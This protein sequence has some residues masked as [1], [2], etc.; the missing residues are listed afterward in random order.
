MTKDNSSDVARIAH[1]PVLLIAGPGTGKTHQLAKRIR[2][3]V[4]KNVDPMTIS[5]IT[6]TGC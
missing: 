6:F 2:Y 4:D 3:L 1:G 5:V